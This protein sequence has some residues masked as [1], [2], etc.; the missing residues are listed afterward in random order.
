M[1][2]ILISTIL[3]LSLSAEATDSNLIFLWLKSFVKE[4]KE[5]KNQC[6]EIQLPTQETTVNIESKS[7]LS[8]F[9]VSKRGELEGA[10]IEFNFQFKYKDYTSSNIQIICNPSSIASVYSSYVLD[11]TVGENCKIKTIKFKDLALSNANDTIYINSFSNKI[12]EKSQGECPIPEAAESA[13]SPA[14]K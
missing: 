6:F 11:I 9:S 8:P 10:I 3:L 12:Y 5:T 13:S 7:V 14:S 2:T 4:T 1:K